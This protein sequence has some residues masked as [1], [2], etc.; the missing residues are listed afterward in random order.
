MEIVYSNLDKKLDVIEFLS[1]KTYNDKPKLFI[2]DVEQKIFD[3]DEFTDVIL[4][5]I[6]K[7]VPK[8][9]FKYIFT[10]FFIRFQEYHT[11]VIQ[12]PISRASVKFSLEVEYLNELVD[13]I[14]TLYDELN[15]KKYSV[16]DVK[17]TIDYKVK[18]VNSNM[19]LSST[20]KTLHL[21]ALHL[22]FIPV[23]QNATSHV[24]LKKV[25]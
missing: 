19:K 10:I 7:N 2:C 15:S 23:R 12:P 17:S 3:S 11:Q 20:Y 21:F 22:G 16:E 24:I 6:R 13:E 14:E 8:E 1:K 9:Y 4:K 25:I 5:N 18:K